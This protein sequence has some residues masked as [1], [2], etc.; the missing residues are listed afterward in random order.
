MGIRHSFTIESHAGRFELVQEQIVQE[1]PFGGESDPWWYYRFEHGEGK[2]HDQEWL[3]DDGLSGDP[4]PRRLSRDKIDPES[5]GW[6]T[7]M[8]V[9][10]QLEPD[11]QVRLRYDDEH[12]DKYGRTLAYVYLPDGRMLNEEL[13]KEGWAKTMRIA[14]NTKYADEFT[15]LQAQARDARKRRWQ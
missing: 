4:E 1:K 6:Q 8:W 12:E 15:E 9:F 14:P 11:A 2:L 3:D 10:N 7:T 5:F 13:L